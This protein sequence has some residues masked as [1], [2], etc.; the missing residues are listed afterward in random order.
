MGLLRNLIN[1]LKPRHAR[2]FEPYES[3]GA[4]L[5]RFSVKTTIL[6]HVFRSLQRH[7][8][9]I[10]TQIKNADQYRQYVYRLYTH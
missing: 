9:D 2:I 3:T 7:Y 6:F 1:V 4:T 8:T 5:Q 10:R